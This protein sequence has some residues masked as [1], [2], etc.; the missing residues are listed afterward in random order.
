MHH[1]GKQLYFKKI[2][3]RFMELYITIEG[4]YVCVDV[5]LGKGA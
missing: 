3:E 1:G 4:I 5:K 2:E